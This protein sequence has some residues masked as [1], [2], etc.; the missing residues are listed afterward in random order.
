MQST[1]G[2]VTLQERMVNLIKQLNM[3]VLESSLVIGKW[4]NRLKIRLEQHI[5]ELLLRLVEPW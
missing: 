1:E 4:V 2:M 5:S 3:P